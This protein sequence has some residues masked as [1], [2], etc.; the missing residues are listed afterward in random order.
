M[1][2][3]GFLKSWG[4]EL[5][6]ALV[7]VGLLGGGGYMLASWRYTAELEAQEEAHGRELQTLRADLEAKRADAE[8]RAR[9]TEARWRADI[10]KVSNDAR[11]EVQAAQR[12]AVAAAAVSDSLRE[13]AAQLARACR[14]PTRNPAP[15]P[16]GQAASAPGTYHWWAS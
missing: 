6:A 14:P 13:R 1:M 9:D 11:N 5:L 8:R 15:A 4:L 2:G 10:D 7:L 12:D 3:L 16:G